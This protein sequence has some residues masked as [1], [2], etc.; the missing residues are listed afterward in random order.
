[1]FIRN[2]EKTNKGSKKKYNYNRLVESY[3]DKNGKS[4][5]RVLLNMGKLEIPKTQWKELAKKIE[6]KIYG[7]EVLPLIV[8]EK[9]EENPIETI[10]EHYS[11]I[12]LEKM[13]KKPE[14]QE[15]IKP[16]KENAKSSDAEKEKIYEEVDI[17]SLK[18]KNA[19]TIGAEYVGLKIWEEIELD[20][21]LRDSG[22]NEEQIKLAK[23]EVIGRMSHQ[24]SERSTR[25]WVQEISAIGELLEL[26]TNLISNNALYRI[27]DKLFENK[28]EIENI[29]RTNEMQKYGLEEKIIL[30]D[31]TNTYFE[32]RC[33]KS[34]KAARS[35]QSKEKRTDCKLVTLGLIIDEKGFAKYS[36][37]FEGNVS[38]P[39]T[40]EKMLEKIEKDNP[41]EKKLF[42]KKPT[43]VMDAG[44]ATEDN[45]K[46]L[47]KKGYTYLVVA[48]K[49][50]DI[51]ELGGAKILENSVKMKDGV[52]AKIIKADDDETL[53]YCSSEGK[54]EKEKS[55]KTF[56]EK[57]F[58]EKLESLKKGLTKKGCTKKYDKILITIGRIKERYSKIAQYYDIKKR[59]GD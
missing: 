10:A 33:L 53:V 41:K 27:S 2:V 8:K 49:K 15:T 39:G 11:K 47:K 25:H 45:L 23:I 44:I 20:K 22:L 13:L 6:E 58:I 38:E 46:L 9:S 34:K 59:S 50:Y 32:G 35:K 54:K 26:N 28:K 51:E 57:T 55:I 19:R 48:R 42:T 1:M 4:T 24:G 16:E 30:Y 14:N 7:K 12:L 40:L 56:F 18:N 31:L 17:N 29:L 36:E 3:R 37:V 52:T 43:I 5:N 21:I